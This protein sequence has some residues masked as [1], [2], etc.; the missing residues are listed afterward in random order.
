MLPFLL[1]EWSRPRQKQDFQAE[2]HNNAGTKLSPVPAFHFCIFSFPQNSTY[3]YSS[4]GTSVLLKDFFLF[5]IP[6]HQADNI[7][8]QVDKVQI[9]LQRRKYRCFL[10]KSPVP[11]H[12]VNYF[13]THLQVMKLP[14]F[15]LPRKRHIP[16]FQRTEKIIINIKE[17]RCDRPGQRIAE[18]DRIN[19]TL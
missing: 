1:K 14:P 3:L 12:F 9:H 6:V 11:I 18:H 5:P 17:N 10:K 15:F 13:Q 7:Q 19:I 16:F 2:K 8:K 4:K